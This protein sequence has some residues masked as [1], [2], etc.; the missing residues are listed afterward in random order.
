MKISFTLLLLWIGIAYSQAQILPIYKN[1]LPFTKE[2]RDRKKEVRISKDS[3]ILQNDIEIGKIR[4]L[5]SENGKETRYIIFLN[6]GK[7]LGDALIKESKKNI[8]YYADEDG[9]ELKSEYP[10]SLDEYGLKVFIVKYFI[11]NKFL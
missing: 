8:L 6:N 10:N 9:S 11:K 2:N 4:K 7:P 5:V 1:N 3:L